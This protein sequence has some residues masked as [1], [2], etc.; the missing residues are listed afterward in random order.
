MGLKV[1]FEEF[2]DYEEFPNSGY[3]YYNDARV[4]ELEFDVD[5]KDYMSK[6]HIGIKY[7]RWYHKETSDSPKEDE[8]NLISKEVDVIKIYKYVNGDEIIL[9][10]KEFKKIEKYIIENLEIC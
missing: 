3:E 6:M 2:P 8:C 4:F 7:K 10:G 9:K 1:H 5:G